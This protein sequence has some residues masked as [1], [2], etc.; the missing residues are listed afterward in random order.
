MSY[1][2]ATGVGWDVRQVTDMGAMFDGATGMR[3]CNKRATND[4]M[5]YGS[6]VWRYSAW[7]SA[8]NGITCPDCGDTQ[9]C[10]VQNGELRGK[11]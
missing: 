2:Q 7:A 4:A 11:I 3:P 8:A 1:D 6:S 10:Q 5:S 9:T